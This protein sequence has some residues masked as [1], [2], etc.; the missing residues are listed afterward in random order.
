[1]ALPA[2]DPVDDER[3]DAEAQQNLTQLEQLKQTVNPQVAARVG[4]IYK[5]SPW[6]PPAVILAMAKTAVSDTTIDAVAPVAAR[7][8]VAELDPNKPKD[9]GWFESIVYR[10]LKAFSR[11]SFAGLNLLPELAQNSA[12]QVFS[13][14][15]P[16]GFD[17]WFKSTS[18]G[19]LMANS[20]E[21]GT[22]FFVGGETAK[23]QARRAREVRG[24][25]NGH[26]WTIG[27]GAA[28]VAFTPGSGA[29]NFMSGFIDA[30]V[31]IGADPTT[32]IAPPIKAARLARAAIPG[33]ADEAALAGARAFARGEAGLDAAESLAFSQSKFGQWITKD[34]RA[35]RLT[36]RI[37]EIASD[38]TRTTETKAF[39]LMEQIDG[40]S[41]EMAMVMA[42]ADTTA[43]VQGLLGEASA[44]LAN[45]P[46]D[47]LLPKDIRDIELAGRFKPF[48][49]D[50]AERIPLFRSARQ[51]LFSLMPEEKLVI[52][53]SGR[54]R[55]KAVRNVANYLRGI[56]IADDTDEF[57]RLMNPFMV[58][59][60][61]ANKANSRVII[62]EAYDEMLKAVYARAGGTSED[63]KKLVQAIIDKK[64]ALI[65]DARAFNAS[66]VGRADDGGFFQLARP[67]FNED[68]VLR[69]FDA[70]KWDSLVLAG[71]GALVEMID[72]IL[73][74]PDFREMRKL[75]GTLKFANRSKT[76]DGA[77]TLVEFA[78]QEIWK[79]LALAS[80]GYIV[81]NMIDAQTRI[82]MSGLSG[83]FRNPFDYIMW[84][85]RR[86][87]RFDITGSEFDDT[88]GKLV[89][90]WSG[91]QNDFFEALTFD[92]YRHLENTQAA[93]ERMLRNGNFS[94]VDRGL[95]RDA[96]TTGYVDNLRQIF[97][98]RVLNRV[99][100]AGLDS[101]NQVERLGRVREWLLSDEGK[102][103][104]DAIRSYLR[105]G[106]KFTDPETGRTG[107]VSLGEDIPDDLL[108][109]W[110]D[111]LSTSKVNTIVRNDLELG[112]VATYNR[113]PLT[114]TDDSGRV[115]AVGTR[116]VNADDVDF[117]RDS[118]TAPE[119]WGQ[120]G[121]IIRLVDSAGDEYEG[122]VIGRRTVET[123]DIDPFT[124][125]PSE[126]G[127][128]LVVQPVHSGEALAGDLGSDE[129]RRL[130]DAKGD[131]G[132]LAGMVKRAERGQAKDGGLQSQFL[133]VKNK[134]TDKFF[135][136]IYGRAT[137]ILEKSPVFRQF[138]YREVAD[139]MDLL[140]PSEAAA[141]L[142]R[143]EGLAAEEGVSAARYIGSK[144]TLDQL[145]K[146]ASSTSDATGTV[147]ELDAYAKAVALQRT[148]ELLYNATERNNL[149]DIMR[150]IVPFGAA[151]REVLGTY[152][153]AGIEDPARLRR[154][155]L[156]FNGFKNFDPDNDGQGFFYTDPVSGQYSF[157][158]PL[159][160]EITQLL[161]GV[162]APLQAPVK[163]ISIGL[164]V[165]PSVG[166]V[167]QILASQLP[168]SP[169]LDSIVGVL[170][171]YGRK[172]IGETLDV[173]PLWAK[174]FGEAMEGNT[175]NM[176]TVF[177]NT[178]IETLRALAASGEYDLSNYDEQ[179]KLYADAR[180]KA[181]TLAKLRALGQFLGPTSP[182]PEFSIDTIKGDIYGSQLVKEFQ[183]LQ[184]ENYD[185]AVARFL[186][187]YGNDAM[188][189]ISNKT[190][191]VVGG[192]EATD[193]FGDWERRGGDAILKKYPAVGG[194]VAP[195]GD[196]FSFEVWSR[197]I[198]KGRRRRLT[199]REIV[200]LA[201]YRA[202][203]ARYRELRDKLPANPSQQQ[204]AWL[205]QWRVQLNKEYPGF[206]VVAEFNPGEFPA[207]IDQLTR[208]VDEPSLADNEVA[209]A[210]RQYLEARRN[211][212]E[213]Y[214]AAGGAESGF[215]Q[216]KAAEPLRDW[217]A[218]IGKALKQETPEFARVYDRL[219][220][221]EVEQ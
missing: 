61:D 104:A 175:L 73:V 35:I 84:A 138:Y 29:Y 25:I 151:W 99:A 141:L 69:N 181:Q 18:L 97:G 42:E 107:F 185:T 92:T 217:L 124:G 27:R 74:L 133:E 206:P 12:A 129:L 58:G 21:A 64:N 89:D 204:K 193:Q 155:Q 26:A 135:V 203:S 186:E 1:M 79:P 52:N 120:P 77:K 184:A 15:D 76:V 63:A 54:D 56:G 131:E 196:D 40:L 199:D 212:V 146:I 220:V 60:S 24:T 106:I 219:L 2:F 80:G 82:A 162:E 87:G 208:M 34:P 214:V 173:R 189:Y 165:I 118:L 160:G 50:Q 164:G 94:L 148:K 188:I 116:T 123:G 158:F 211:A 37:V 130:I 109:A 176:Q 13:D 172:T 19:S 157:N 115:R 72:D 187:I 178:Y 32:V 105:R 75:T 66:E 153:K 190:E 195:G 41:P 11:W 10:P 96:H 88:I 127:V 6:L 45:N 39:Q 197:Q 20:K 167:G 179:E 119:T 152:I 101:E 67:Y 108:V 98:D 209:G 28:N 145:K 180:G 4:D 142:R 47:I 117:P 90:N 210:I 161:T 183:R 95:D 70:D 154:A 59:L 216:A 218:S 132:K 134:L 207:K 171:P 139:T 62:K 16:E 136:D 169:D 103:T 194:F 114:Y 102:E 8:S 215:S 128:K 147:D 202:A 113:V 200:A 71:P 23:D 22:G 31:A 36:N 122:L 201:Q 53:G 81:R 51:R 156:I 30:A 159:S 198:E 137:Q 213:R 125:M 49:S 78:Q 14:N 205:R 170:L 65:S 150:V 163:R 46:D 48:I 174:R 111:R 43:K 86:K 7:K 33:I 166:P 57:A 144:K 93:K 91:E 126:P 121:S 17:G 112:I 5:R 140:A 191:S 100:R 143:V 44:R 68:E 9:R 85:T 182:S 192:L 221:N 149:T 3:S 168:E 177:A 83:V 38:T 55:A 110:V